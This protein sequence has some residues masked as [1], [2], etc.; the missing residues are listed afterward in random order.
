MTLEAIKMKVI[1]RLSG[2]LTDDWSD[3]Q[4]FS[5]PDLYFI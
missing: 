2:S 1:S 3:N 4:A 5:L